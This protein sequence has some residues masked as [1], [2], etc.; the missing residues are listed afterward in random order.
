MACVW[1]GWGPDQALPTGIKP[2][3]NG[4]KAKPNRSEEGTASSIVGADTA[5][6]V[7]HLCLNTVVPSVVPSAWFPGPWHMADTAGRRDS[8]KKAAAEAPD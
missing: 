1:K 3:N 7:V 5:T 4:S 6:L 2:L 8:S